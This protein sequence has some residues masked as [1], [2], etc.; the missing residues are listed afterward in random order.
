VKAGYGKARITPPVGV[1]TVLGV[2][3]ELVRVL[4]DLFVRAICIEVGAERVIV[5]AADIIGLD[6]GDSE[7]FVS[8]IAK[9]T[10]TCPENVVVHAIHTHQTAN[11]HWETAAILEPYGLVDQYCSQQFRALVAAGYQRAAQDAVAKLRTCEMYFTS[12]PASGIASN[13]RVPV[14]GQGGKVLFRESRPN[15]ALRAYPEGPIDPLVRLL[16]FRMEES[17]E[18]IGISNYNCH[19]TAAGGDAGAYATGDYPGV[20]MS[21]AEGDI[22]GLSLLH[23]TGA[24]GEINPGKY[25]SSDSYR[26]EDRQRDT[27]RLGSRYAT[28]IVSAVESALAANSWR[29]TDTLVMKAVNP[30]RLSI[31]PSLP[32]ESALLASIHDAVAAYRM[33]K[34]AGAQP[35]Q[36]FQRDLRKVMVWRKTRDGALHTQAAAMRLGDVVINFMPGEI[37]LQFGDMLREQLGEP[38]LINAAYCFGSSFGYV[39]PPEAFARGGYEPTA[40]SLAPQAYGELADQIMGL[41]RSLGPS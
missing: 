18:L 10:G 8:M 2:E 30:L 39:V 40:T 28:A 15:A 34:P 38:Y 16:L 26:P 1:A 41:L 27:W 6:P 13:R 3:A 19:P 35:R 21:M 29:S 23:L 25:V 33:Q 5:A 9:A 31:S 7:D 11:S 24:C 37:F 22:P 36:P 12:A 14:P 32:S 4:D 17:G 20:G